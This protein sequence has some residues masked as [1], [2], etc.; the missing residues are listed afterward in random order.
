VNR[1]IY[2][3]QAEPQDFKVPGATAGGPTCN[4]GISSLAM[5]PNLLLAGSWDNHIRCWQVNKQGALG[6]QLAGQATHDGPVLSTCFNGDASAAISGGADN[7][8][9]VWQFAGSTGAT[10][11]GRHD[12]PVKSVHWVPNLNMIASA[13]WD[14][15]VSPNNAIM[16]SRFS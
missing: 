3:L 15:T 5:S 6:A 7:T 1:T 8:V 14:R 11:V 4:D 9:R 12:Q 16:H 10:V 13:S 2:T